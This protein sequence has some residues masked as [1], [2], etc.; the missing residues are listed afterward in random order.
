[1]R[2]RMTVDLLI[3]GREIILMNIGDHNEVYR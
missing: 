1:M 2:Y 3:Q